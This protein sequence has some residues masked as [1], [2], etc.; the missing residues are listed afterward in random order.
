M[1]NQAFYSIRKTKDLQLIKLGED[2][3][4]FGIN[5]YTNEI[6]QKFNVIQV[7]DDFYDKDFFNEIPVIRLADVNSFLPIINCTG[8][9]LTRRNFVISSLR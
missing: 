6:I 4:V 9:K 3:I 8:G 2:V 1:V 7:I 5:V